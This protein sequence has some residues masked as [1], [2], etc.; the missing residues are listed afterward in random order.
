MSPYT[1]V[2]DVIEQALGS[3]LTVGLINRRWWPIGDDTRKRISLAYFQYENDKNRFKVPEKSISEIFPYVSPRWLIA[4]DLGGGIVSDIDA[5]IRGIKLLLLYYH[6]I[7]LP[8]YFGY[9][10]DF[11]RIGG[12]Q[13]ENRVQFD[14]HLKLFAELRPL[15]KDG[16]V[17]FAPEPLTF[18]RA[19]DAVQQLVV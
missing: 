12:S 3:R 5:V 14:A 13:P 18:S 10:C 7:A 9:L 17:F 8:D 6:R 16:T 11:Y 2:V 15:I 4:D 19:I 1:N